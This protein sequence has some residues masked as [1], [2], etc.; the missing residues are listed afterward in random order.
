[1]QAVDLTER[2]PVES[3]SM[4]AFTAGRLSPSIAGRMI[5]A[6]KLTMKKVTNTSTDCAVLHSHGVPNIT[7]LDWLK[8]QIAVRH[9][10]LLL[11]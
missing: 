10:L 8:V 6:A 2:G 9:W 3:F 1:M 11:N 4:H 5:S 7:L